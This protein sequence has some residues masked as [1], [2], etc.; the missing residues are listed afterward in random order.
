MNATVIQPSSSGYSAQA[1][2]SLFLRANYN[3]R[4]K[5]LVSLIG[6]RD[7]SS[8]LTKNNRTRNYGSASVGWLMSK[9]DFLK[10]VS[11]LNELKLRGSYGFLGNLAALTSAAVNPLLSPTQ[12]YFGQT[13]TLQNGY[14]QTVLANPNIAWAESKQTNF[15]VDVA[16]LGRLSLTAD[17]F[18]KEINKMILVRTLPGTAGLGTQTINARK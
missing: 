13:P 10:D 2:S 3:Y 17:Y 1:L 18:V 7:G 15:G 4:E 12:S 8:L 9:E 14:V 6:R 5:Y 16:V 11:W